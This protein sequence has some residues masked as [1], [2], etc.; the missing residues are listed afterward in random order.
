MKRPVDTLPGE[1]LKQDIYIYT[2]ILAALLV[3][4]LSIT[5]GEVVL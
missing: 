5:Q 3:S 1:S 2:H 4:A